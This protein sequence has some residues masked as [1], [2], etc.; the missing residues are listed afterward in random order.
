M[1]E[2]M[3]VL[4]DYQ[5]RTLINLIISIVRDAKKA[6]IPWEDVEEKLIEIRDGEYALRRKEDKESDS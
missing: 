5:L 6:K 1:E 2:R 4:T 3:D